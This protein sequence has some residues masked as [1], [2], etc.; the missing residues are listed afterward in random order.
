MSKEEKLTEKV[1]Q[2]AKEDFE[3]SP[4]CAYYRPEEKQRWRENGGYYTAEELAQM[5]R[6]CDVVLLPNYSRVLSAD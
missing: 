3:K 2:T 1:K 4:W 5:Q 6:D